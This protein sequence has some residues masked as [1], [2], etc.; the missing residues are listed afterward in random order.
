MITR[1]P[2]NI[3][4]IRKKKIRWEEYPFYCGRGKRGGGRG[5]GGQFRIIKFIARG[6][7]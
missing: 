5:E 3:Y 4:A 7:E 1:K 6:D 2:I